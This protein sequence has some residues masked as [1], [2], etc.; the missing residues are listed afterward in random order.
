MLPEMTLVEA[1]ETIFRHYMMGLMN[2]PT[3]TV[4]TLRN[5]TARCSPFASPLHAVVTL[6]P[7]RHRSVPLLADSCP[8]FLPLAPC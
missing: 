8:Q 6:R 3:A 7:R 5:M 4:T 1:C 2:G